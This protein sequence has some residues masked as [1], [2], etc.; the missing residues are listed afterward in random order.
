MNQDKAY[1]QNLLRHVE[2]TQLETVGELLQ[3]EL[4]IYDI[5]KFLQEM[6]Q[7]DE[8]DNPRLD[9]LKLGLRQLRKEHEILS[10][11]IGDL[12]LDISHAKFMIDILSR[13][14]DDE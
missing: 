11:E 13:D 8:Y 6:R 1:Y 3:I 14:K 5:R 7:I 2:Y 10:H 4:A 12:E 9:N